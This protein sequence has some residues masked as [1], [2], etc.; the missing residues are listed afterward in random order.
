MAAGSEAPN[1][2]RFADERRRRNGPGE[3]VDT[4]A[5]HAVKR[6][7]PGRVLEE[8]SKPANITPRGTRAVDTADV[9]DH[10]NDPDP[11]GRRLASKTPHDVGTQ[12]PSE[13]PVSRVSLHDRAQSVVGRLTKRNQ[14]DFAIPNRCEIARIGM[15]VLI[16]S[17]FGP[18][19]A[20]LKLLRACT[21]L[22]VVAG[23]REFHAVGNDTCA[24][25]NQG[26]ASLFGP[27][28]PAKRERVAPDRT[29]N[30]VGKCV[31][32]QT[33]GGGMKCRKCRTS[34][35]QP[36]PVTG[37][38]RIRQV[39]SRRHKLLQRWIRSLRATRNSGTASCSASRLPVKSSSLATVHP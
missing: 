14:I 29:H 1:G 38:C 19:V 6:A 33:Q 28:R 17:V 30:G 7:A 22:L 21:L 15:T 20:K 23:N 26:P 5:P 2:I 13:S 32:D 12:G 16:K 35:S 3:S 36:A 31:A 11:V 25:G 10:G 24:E 18:L 37:G 39:S 27:L 8:F 34:E 9:A 4:T